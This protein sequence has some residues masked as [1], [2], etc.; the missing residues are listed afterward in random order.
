MMIAGGAEWPAWIRPAAGIVATL[1]SVAALALLLLPLVLVLLMV[2]FETTAHG[3]LAL[4]GLLLGWLRAFLPGSRYDTAGAGFDALGVALDALLRALPV[5]GGLLA[6]VIG[7][8]PRY[9][10]VAL[11]LWGLAAALDGPVIAVVLG[12][13]MAGAALC[14][15]PDG[16]QERPLRPRRSPSG[17]RTVPAD[18]G[19]GEPQAQGSTADQP[20]DAPDPPGGQ[21]DQQQRSPQG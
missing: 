21:G 14:A 5:L 2:L 7:R 4:F 20:D 19:D 9:W 15:V 8:R 12:P 16:R 1:C 11:L 3:V 18:G 10:C 13:A 17:D 6:I